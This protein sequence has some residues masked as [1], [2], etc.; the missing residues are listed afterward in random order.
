MP[1]THDVD[2][3]NEIHAGD[4]GEVEYGTGG[5]LRSF[6]RPFILIYA[7]I[8]IILCCIELLKNMLR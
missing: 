5:K 3:Q 2:K 8:A 6:K 4:T 1:T 7:L